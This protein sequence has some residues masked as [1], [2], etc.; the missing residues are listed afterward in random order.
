MFKASIRFVMSA[1]ALIILSCFCGRQWVESLLPFLRS[2]LH[3]LDDSYRILNLTLAT[4]DVDSVISL[5]VTL[6]RYIVHGSHVIAPD[7][8][9]HAVVT[10]LASSVIR[11]A[12]FALVMLAT[13]PASQ[14]RQ[15][16]L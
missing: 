16:A 1:A 2:E 3:W 7:P 10:T 14:L 13:W 5:D 4:Q 9:G 11:P 8:R 12:I 6:A 15:Y